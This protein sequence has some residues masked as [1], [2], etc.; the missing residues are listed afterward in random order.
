VIAS[1]F[2]SAELIAQLTGVGVAVV[3][4][5]LENSAIGN[6]P[7]ILLLGYMLGT[8]DR[9]L[10]LA[11][12]VTARVNAVMER[13]NGSGGER[14]RVL[15]ISRYTETFAAGSGSTEGGIIEAA[16]GINAAA[17]AGIVSHQNIGIEGI[18]ALAP[19]IIFLAQPESSAVEFAEDLYADPALSE[20]PAVINRKIMV[21]N[22]IFHT[23]LSHWNVRGIEESARVFFP[24]LFEGVTFDEFSNP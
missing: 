17:E 13:I 12:E 6:V 15:S 5:D 21:S 3:K 10:A 19:D 1:A 14:P 24:E 23:T 11:A 18:A 7:N 2:T 16:G 22:P 9:A 8:E 20:V 4:A